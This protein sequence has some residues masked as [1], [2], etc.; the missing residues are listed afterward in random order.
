LRRSAHH[1]QMTA[2]HR[3]QASIYIL[4]SGIELCWSLYF[5]DRGRII[6][7]FPVTTERIPILLTHRILRLCA[8]EW[9]LETQGL[10]SR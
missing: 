4:K 8:T 10:K 5:I 3:M 6:G 7:F 2:P 9:L 1:T